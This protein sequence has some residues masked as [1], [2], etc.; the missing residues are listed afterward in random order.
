MQISLRK[1]N[2]ELKGRA[3]IKYVDLDKYPEG[4]KELGLEDVRIPT[5]VLFNSDGTPY[6]TTK[7]EIFGY[8]K[9]NDSQGNHILTLHDGD[10]TYD[11]MGEIINELGL[12]QN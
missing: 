8:K 12:K 6:K 1:L 2:R 3:I 4:V 10:L 9:I 5:Q 7:S 11:D